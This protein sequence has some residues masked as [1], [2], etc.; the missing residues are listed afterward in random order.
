MVLPALIDAIVGVIEGAWEAGPGGQFIAIAA[1]L[2]AL[3]VVINIVVGVF[4]GLATIIG[5]V[6]GIFNFLA[7]IISLVASVFQYI[8][9]GALVPFIAIIAA[10]AGAVMIGIAV[11]RNWND[12]VKMAGGVLEYTIGTLQQAL[13]GLGEW[14]IPAT[15]LKTPV[16]V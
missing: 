11:F 3:M 1:G 14:V 13:G 12:I 6:M 7:P 2:A 10:I 15:I 4:S 9:T 5:V 8:V 16:Q